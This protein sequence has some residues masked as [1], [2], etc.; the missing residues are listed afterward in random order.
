MQNRGST[1]QISP[2]DVYEALKPLALP[3]PDV[4]NVSAPFQE[5]DE[6][7]PLS[8]APNRFRRRSEMPGSSPPLADASADFEVVSTRFRGMTD[9]SG[10][11][12]SARALHENAKEVIWET[13][14][15]LRGRALEVTDPEERA[16]LI[17]FA[18]SVDKLLDSPL[19]LEY[20]EQPQL[21]REIT[22]YLKRYK[23]SQQV[24]SN[25]QEI[26]D[27]VLKASVTA[28]HIAP[29]LGFWRKSLN[30][31]PEVQKLLTS[32]NVFG[33]VFR[34]AKERKPAWVDRL[35][36]TYN[37]TIGALKN[38][39]VMGRPI[40]I[41]PRN[42]ILWPW[43]KFNIRNVTYP[44]HRSDASRA[45]AEETIVD[46]KLVLVLF[47]VLLDDVADNLQDANVLRLL[48]QIPFAGGAFG[49]AERDAY[50]RLRHGLREVGW[51]DL[52][53]YFDLAVE[54]WMQALTKLKEVVG[55]AYGEIEPELER[56]YTQILSS[57]RLSVDL[58][59]RPT[60]ILGMAPSELEREYGSAHVGEVLNHNANRMAFFT[61]DLMCLRA[62]DPYRY[63]ELVGSGAAEVYRHSA[64]IFQDMQQIG[65]SVSTGARETSSD[66]I[67]NELF[68]I[69][70]DRLNTASDWPLPVHLEQVPGF[71]RKDA[72]L[73]AFEL[74]KAAKR[75]MGDC[76]PGSNEHDAAAREYV[77]LGDDIEHM[78]DLSGAEHYY[79]HHWLKRREEVLDLFYKCEDWMDHY[80]LMNANDLVLVLHL[81]YKGRI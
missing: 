23:A 2:A 39:S 18:E 3:G 15:E 38:I 79:F 40:D 73:K 36:S 52:E 14:G 69:A 48:L 60:E 8:F 32:E 9:L 68:K 76:A 54:T 16:R 57:M 62:F 10:R 78:V 64:L 28:I 75:A 29:C 45:A 47:N 33:S 49:I 43:C 51:S 58:N 20:L 30:V 80:Q 1:D 56:D 72:L 74:K 5:E 35:L 17:A 6:P 81:M 46:V 59:N 61:I 21:S 11:F 65:N 53:A 63:K 71:E 50:T 66:D 22:S 77:A 55:D 27:V 31:P 42:P 12:G 19:A 13:S 26:R 41:K 44:L 7:E 37:K 67:T 25:D 34:I 4:V 24:W 70:N